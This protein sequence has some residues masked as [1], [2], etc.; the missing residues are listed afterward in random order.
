MTKTKVLRSVAVG[1]GFLVSAGLWAAEDGLQ[2]IP[3]NAPYSYAL[4]VMENDQAKDLTSEFNKFLGVNVAKG[5]VFHARTHP[6]VK[7]P[8]GDSRVELDLGGKA[9]LI[10]ITELTPQTL[11]KKHRYGA[12]GEPL[13]IVVDGQGRTKYTK[14]GKEREI[15]WNPN[16]LFAVPPGSW[17]E[18]TLAPGTRSAR[19]LEYVGYGVNAF[20]REDIAMNR[21]ANYAGGNY[22]TEWVTDSGPGS[23][24]SFDNLKWPGSYFPN[25]RDPR[26]PVEERIVLDV[27]RVGHRTHPLVYINAE[28]APVFGAQQAQGAH[29]HGGAGIYYVLKGRGYDEYWREGESPKR[30]EYSEGDIVGIPVGSYN[31]H[32]YNSSPIEVL[33]NI[34]VVPRYAE[35]K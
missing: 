4:Q 6:V 29:R 2:H 33:R 28:D 1:I 19:L 30:H 31:H 22:P 32:H 23:P 10:L 14:D 34:A 26:L 16:D 25:I 15:Q 17:I 7:S 9:Q 8:V 21:G 12:A 18:H 27:S 20:S 24:L 5:V 3:Q 13:Y 35:I 11:S